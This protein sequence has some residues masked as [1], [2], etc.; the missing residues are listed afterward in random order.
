[1]R[2]SFLSRLSYITLPNYSGCRIRVASHFNIDNWRQLLLDYSNVRICDLLEFGFPIG[3]RQHTNFSC[4]KQSRNQSRQI[5]V[6]PR[7]WGY[8]AYSWKA[9]IFLDMVFPMGLRSACLNCQRVTNAIAH[10]CREQSG[11]EMVNYVNDFASAEVVKLAFDGYNFLGKLFI[12][13]G[14]LEAPDKAAPPSTKMTFLLDSVAMTMEI[15]ADRLTELLTLLT[16]WEIGTVATKRDVQSLIGKLVFVAVCIKPGRLF[17]SRM[18]NFLQGMRDNCEVT[19]PHDFYKDVLWWRAFMPLYNRVSMM[20]LEQFDI[21]DSV[22]ASDACLSGCGAVCGQ[23]YF[24][25][26]FPQFISAL[27]LDIICLELLTISVCAKLWGHYWKGKSILFYC[28]NIVSVMVLNSGKTR[29]YFL[30][31]CLREI[32]FYAAKCEFEIHGVHIAGCDNHLPDALSRWHLGDSYKRTFFEGID[33]GEWEEEIIGTSYLHF[34][35]ISNS[36]VRL[37]LN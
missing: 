18:L 24:H 15:T 31:Q 26:K 25:S 16:S 7:D 28:D 19:L 27:A 6:D 13:L 36:L 3:L 30:Q 10:V 12:T 35:M 9:H 17:I 32:S 21:P 1:M 20:F 11:F 2:A 34:L 14:L 4:N 29:H 22:A 33:D 23:Q 5:P 8:L 37:K